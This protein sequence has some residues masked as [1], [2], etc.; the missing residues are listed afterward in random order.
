MLSI[1]AN[2]VAGKAVEYSSIASE[3]A[4]EYTQTISEKV[5]KCDV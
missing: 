2:K 5:R 3:K 4:S 1:G